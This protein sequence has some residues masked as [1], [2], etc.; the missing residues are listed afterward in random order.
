[1]VLKAMK[2]HFP[3]VDQSF[4][5]RGASNSIALSSAKK[6]LPESVAMHPSSYITQRLSQEGLPLADKMG[7]DGEVLKEPLVEMENVNVRYGARQILGGWKQDFN[8]KERDGLWWTIRRGERWGV[9]GPNGDFQL[10]DIFIRMLLS[11]ARF[12]KDNTVIPDLLRSPPVIL[13]SYQ[14]LWQGTLAKIGSAWD[15]HLRHPNPN[16]TVVPGDSWFFP[17]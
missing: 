2:S 13:S 4:P 1:M 11:Q 7:L 9:F 5:L 6:E 10:E 12:G 3:H 17:S 15:F 8:G 14:D 16:R